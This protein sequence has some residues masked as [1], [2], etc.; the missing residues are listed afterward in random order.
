[1]KENHSRPRN[2]NNREEGNSH[3]SNLLKIEQEHRHEIQHRYLATYRLG[4]LLGL[5]Y[6]LALLFLVYF[7][8]KNGEKELAFKIFALNAAVIAFTILTLLI[9]KKLFSRRVDNKRRGRFDNR[10]KNNREKSF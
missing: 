3:D 4:Q 10:N 9:D 1:M 2:F 7:L 6:N 5:I 8:I